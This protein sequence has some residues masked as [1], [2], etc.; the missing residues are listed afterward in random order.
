MPR[1]YP[2]A[3]KSRQ[4]FLDHW[5]WSKPVWGLCFDAV[6]GCYTHVIV[7]SDGKDFVY[8]LSEPLHSVK[9]NTAKTRNYSSVPNDDVMAF[10]ANMSSLKFGGDKPYDMKDQTYLLPT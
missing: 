6:S 2:D 7:R 10:A 4:S 9:S 1:E 5:D 8:E 3:R